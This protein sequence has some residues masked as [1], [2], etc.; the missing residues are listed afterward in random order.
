M[1]QDLAFVPTRLLDVER[2]DSGLIRLVEKGTGDSSPKRYLALS[3]RW[4]SPELH[5]TFC[6]H[7]HNIMQFKQ[8]IRLA[9]LP[10][11]FHDAVQV[12]RNLGVRYLWIDS[13]CIIQDDPEDWNTES[14]AM[15]QVF[16]S[17]YVTI[18]AICSSGT[19]DGF[20]KPRPNRQC[21]IAKLP[22]DNGVLYY[23]CKTVDDFR[24]DIDESELS[25]RA[26]VLQERALSR[27]TIYFSQ[28]Q[29]YWECGRGV[30]CETLTKMEK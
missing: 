12:T 22:G 1:L 24:N 6:T 20:L 15:E 27:R 10:R 28:T 2:A 3:H 26:W 18:S 21:V 8:V 7:T 14:K 23:L 9:D 29:S 13:L 30:R 11:T 4:G 5:R 17:A 25:K 19:T 16:S